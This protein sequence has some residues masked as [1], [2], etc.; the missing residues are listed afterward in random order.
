MTLQ[1]KLHWKGRATGYCYAATKFDE[2]GY[3]H[4][5]R[6]CPHGPST[7]G[8]IRLQL[9]HGGFVVGDRDV[10]LEELRGS[11]AGGEWRPCTAV[12]LPAPMT[13]DAGRQVPC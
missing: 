6:R 4:R 3:D 5:R 8:R 1:P 13:I 2:S 10:E 9:V 11:L 7:S 12:L